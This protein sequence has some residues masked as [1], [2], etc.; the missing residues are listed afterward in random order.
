MRIGLGDTTTGVATPV[1][2][3]NT[4]D[5]TAVAAATNLNPIQNLPLSMPDVTAQIGTVTYT[6]PA[7]TCPSG[8]TCTILPGSGIPDIAVYGVGALFL[9]ML[10]SSM[11]G[12]R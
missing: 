2:G 5:P 11:G 1:L 3:V 9:F 12:R 7:T 8:Y 4:L 6:P 10:F